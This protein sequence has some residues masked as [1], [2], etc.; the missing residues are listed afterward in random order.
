MIPGLSF[1]TLG[2]VDAMTQT[3]IRCFG[4]AS[5][6]RSLGQQSFRQGHHAESGCSYPMPPWYAVNWREDTLLR[7]AFGGEEKGAPIVIH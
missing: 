6:A 7:A 5:G 4:R 3:G 1:P 2:V